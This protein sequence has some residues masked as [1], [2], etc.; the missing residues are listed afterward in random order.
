[1]SG[2]SPRMRGSRGWRNRRFVQGGIIPADAGLTLNFWNLLSIS[3]DHPRGCGAHEI[4]PLAAGGVLGSSPRMRGSPFR[5]G[6]LYLTSGIIPA[7]AGLTDSAQQHGGRARDHP[8]GCGAHRIS[9]PARASTS[10]SSP[11]MR[12]SRSYYLDR[13]NVWGIIPADAG[14]TGTRNSGIAASQDHPRG[15]GAHSPCCSPHLIWM[16]SSPRMRGSQL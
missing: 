10:G 12:G 13:N 14:L 1:M 2:S 15:C 5:V 4:V 6:T 9:R 7:D 16:G 3:R 11:R 8:R